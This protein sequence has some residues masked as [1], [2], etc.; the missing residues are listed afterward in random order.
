[1][2]FPSVVF[3][4]EASLAH[5]RAQLNVIAQYIHSGYIFYDLALNFYDGITF[6]T[7]SIATWTALQAGKTE[8]NG[9]LGQACLVGATGGKQCMVWSDD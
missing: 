8:T 4:H 6:K 5:P 7:G 3:Y 9:V 2:E 1:M